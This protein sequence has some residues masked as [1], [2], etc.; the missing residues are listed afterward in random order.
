MFR[1]ARFN[2]VQNELINDCRHNLDQDI[3]RRT[4][5]RSGGGEEEGKKGRWEEES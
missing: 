4:R 3:M 2:V 5:G 1:V